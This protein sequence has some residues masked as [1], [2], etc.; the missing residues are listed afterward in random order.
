MKKGFL[1][2]LLGVAT[3]VLTFF[4]IRKGDNDTLYYVL[5]QDYQ[6][7]NIGFLKKGTIIKFEQGMDEGFDRYSLYL[8]LKNGNLIKDTQHI[9]YVV[10]YW[11]VEPSQAE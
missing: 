10:P 1:Y 7:D 2:F 3:S 4:M 8:N 9:E 6:I 5:N 11:L